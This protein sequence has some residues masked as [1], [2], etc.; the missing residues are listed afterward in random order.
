[1]SVWEIMDVTVLAQT[2]LDHTIAAVMMVIDWN[3]MDVN[4][5]VTSLCAVR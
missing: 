3:L 2:H 5:Q 4:V 1:M